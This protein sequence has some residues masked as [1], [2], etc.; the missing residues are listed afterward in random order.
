MIEFNKK[1][2][3][4]SKEEYAYLD[5]GQGEPIILVHGNM[6]SSVH[7]LPLIERLKD[8]YRCVAPDLRGFGDS[9]YNREFSSMQEL[10]EDVYEFMQAL[11]IPKARFVCWSAGCPV[12]LCLAIA[13]PEAVAGIFAIEGGSCQGYPIYKKNK[14]MI[15]IYGSAYA[16][17]AEMGA[18]PVQV[19]P[20]L[21]VLA[22]K[23]AAAMAAVWDSV[24]YTANKP[25]KDD[26]DLYISETLKQ[27]CLLDLDWA[28]ATV[29][30]SDKQNAYGAGDNTI[31]KVKCPCAFTM[32][33]K[34]ISVPD[35]M[36]MENVN[37]IKGSKL[38]AYVD[39]GHSPLVDCPDAL[40]KDVKEFF[41]E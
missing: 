20:M 8:S 6:S 33:D 35:W 37:A 29:N 11:N 31:S 38:I 17:K 18:D 39:C 26:N 4:L 9:S 24:I 1:T 22:S 2:I 30:L 10:A 32:A 21:N 23:S 36:V 28:L 16:S 14:E 13:H 40:A 7:Y 34:D 41:G 12:T 25:E 27:R 5:I 15:S 3:K 19:A